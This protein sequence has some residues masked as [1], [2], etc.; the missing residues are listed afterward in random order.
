M[1]IGHQASMVHVID[2]GL[3][4][5]FRSPDTHLHIPLHWG[6]KRGLTGS[7]LFVLNNS[8]AGCELRRWDNL[9]SLTYV[10][11]YFLRGGLPWEGLVNSDLVA[12][13]KLESSAEDLCN[14]LPVKYATLLSYSQVLPFNAKP[15]YN[16]ISRLFGGSVPHEGTNPVFDW[17]SGLAHDHINAPYT[18]LPPSI[19]ASHM[20]RAQAIPIHH[21]G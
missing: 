3:S 13:Y 20:G 14:G 1:G 9:K 5:E 15:D 6:M 10:L 12:Q 18:K 7:V 8:H 16:Y 21:T 11:I 19:I 4:K 17:D 2:F